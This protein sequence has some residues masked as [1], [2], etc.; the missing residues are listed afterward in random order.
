[1]SR[2]VDKINQLNHDSTDSNDLIEKSNLNDSQMIKNSVSDVEKNNKR[3]LS[4]NDL[5]DR[6]LYIS[7]SDLSKLE[8]DVFELLVSIFKDKIQPSLLENI[9]GKE[10]HGIY[11]SSGSDGRNL[12]SLTETMNLDISE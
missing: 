2:S 9:E 1:M 11:Q 12:E 10:F 6:I 8:A 3:G 4:M 7:A 5:V